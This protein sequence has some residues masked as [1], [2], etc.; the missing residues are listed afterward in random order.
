MTTNL[1]FDI[2]RT[3]YDHVSAKADLARSCLVSKELLSIAQPLLYSSL[4]FT[5]F[6]FYKMPLRRLPLSIGPLEFYHDSRVGISTELLLSTLRRNSL[7]RSYVRQ[8]VV[9]GSWRTSQQEKPKTNLTTME[10]TL[11]EELL[12]LLPSAEGFVLRKLLNSLDVDR[13]VGRRQLQQ[14]DGQVV[15]NFCLIDPVVLPESRTEGLKARY[16][17]FALFPRAGDTQQVGL[18]WLLHNSKDSV[19]GLGI[20]FEESTVLSTFTQLTHLILYIRNENPALVFDHLFAT[21][22]SLDTLRSLHLASLDQPIPLPPIFDLG[23]FAKSLPSLLSDLTLQRFK[24]PTTRV[25]SF[26]RNLDS[27]TSLKRFRCWKANDESGNSLSDERGGGE[28]KND[29]AVNPVE[30]Y[31]KR[32]ITLIYVES[33]R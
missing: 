6:S 25:I 23:K 18:D 7:I 12:S 20:P 4:E 19:T 16:N 33:I 32:G 24:V 14:E 31:G 11:L 2:F 26:L 1:P 27:S 8:V 5:V 17:G 15:P 28:A 30:E 13:V 3:I 9:E 21:I 22:S 29:A 10:S